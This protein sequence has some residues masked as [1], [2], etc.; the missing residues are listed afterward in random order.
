MWSDYAFEYSRKLSASEQ[1]Y[2]QQSPYSWEVDRQIFAS[3]RYG[4]V[5]KQIC[6]SYFRRADLPSPLLGLYFFYVFGVF[7]DILW[8]FGAIWDKFKCFWAFW[9]VLGCFAPFCDVLWRFGMLLDTFGHFRALWDVLGYCQTPD[10]TKL[11]IRSNQKSGEA[12]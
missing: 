6:P 9:D 10:Q 11:K 1:K 8:H 12:L 3:P 4:E 5:D 2:R 7:W